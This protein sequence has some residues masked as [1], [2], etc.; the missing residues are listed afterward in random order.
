MTSSLTLSQSW[1][2]DT[3]S[4]NRPS[5]KAAGAILVKDVRAALTIRCSR[6][7][8]R[9][10]KSIVS[11]RFLAMSSISVSVSSTTGSSSSVRGMPMSSSLSVTVKEKLGRE[12]ADTSRCDNGTANE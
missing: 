10:G 2:P 7:L 11:L 12:T 5:G 6:A 1:C 9:K 4:W 3:S 8:G